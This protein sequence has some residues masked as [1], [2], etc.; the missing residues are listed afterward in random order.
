M[1][2][3]ITKNTFLYIV[4]SPKRFSCDGIS[5]KYR[6]I[7]AFS[8]G[9]ILPRTLGKASERN[10]FKRRCRFIIK[11]INVNLSLPLVGIIIIPSHLNFNYMELFGCFENLSNNILQNVKHI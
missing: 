8:L 7:D 11:N 10:L 5:F 2:F 3:S 6:F 4:D 9:F 1:S